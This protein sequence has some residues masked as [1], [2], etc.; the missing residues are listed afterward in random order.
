[1]HTASQL[2][3]GHEHEHEQQRQREPR[4]KDVQLEMKDQQQRK[5]KGNHQKSDGQGHQSLHQRD[6]HHSVSQQQQDQNTQHQGY[7][8]KY[9]TDLSDVKNSKQFVKNE[10]TKYGESVQISPHHSPLVG[11]FHPLIPLKATIPISHHDN[12]SIFTTISATTPLQTSA[13]TPFQTSTITPLQ[14]SAPAPLEVS[15]SMPASA[16]LIEGDR[17]PVREVRTIQLR[18]HFTTLYCQDY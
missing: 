18:F 5:G 9:L 16:L 10:V 3:P 6:V 13:T 8:S 2:L 1:M 11:D 14:T 17:T 7:P 4:R 12:L 15:A